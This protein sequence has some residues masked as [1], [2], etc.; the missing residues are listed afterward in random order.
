LALLLVVGLAVA[1]A[2]GAIGID[3][4][5][6]AVLSAESRATRDQRLVL[7]LD[8]SIRIGVVI[9]IGGACDNASAL[10]GLSAADRWAVARYS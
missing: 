9:A 7:L 5:A 10:D 4:T 6:S 8:R 1:V 3:L 2:V